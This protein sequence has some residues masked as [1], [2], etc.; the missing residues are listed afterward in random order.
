MITVIHP[1]DQ[2]VQRGMHGTPIVISRS[3]AVHPLLG[4]ADGVLPLFG[5]TVADHGCTIAGV[6]TAR[7]PWTR[8]ISTWSRLR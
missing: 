2:G 5:L 8:M 3:H 6:V 1:L 4:L 7:S